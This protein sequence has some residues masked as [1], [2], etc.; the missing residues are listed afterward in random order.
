MLEEQ[1][2][3]FRRLL[4]KQEVQ[5]ELARLQALEALQEKFDKE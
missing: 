2:G 1:V 3:E 4:K 5:F